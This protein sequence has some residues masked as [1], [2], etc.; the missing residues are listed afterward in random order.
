MAKKKVKPSPEPVFLRTLKCRSC[1]R[2]YEAEQGK[3]KCPN[4][5]STN[6]LRIG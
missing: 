5:D 3:E 1:G 6:A 2:E 4:C